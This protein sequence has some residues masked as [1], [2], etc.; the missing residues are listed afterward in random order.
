[1]AVRCSAKVAAILDGVIQNQT[2]EVLFQGIV[3]SITTWRLRFAATLASPIQRKQLRGLT[4]ILTHNSFGV[5]NIA[6]IQQVAACHIKSM[7]SWKFF[8]ISS[9]VLS[10]VMPNE[11]R[12]REWV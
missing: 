8:K 11:L 1:M 7:F 6:L 4:H 2:D 5:K 10:A 12:I 3:K 9:L